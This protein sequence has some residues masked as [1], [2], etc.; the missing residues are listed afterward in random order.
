MVYNARGWH[1]SYHMADCALATSWRDAEN[2]TLLSNGIARVSKIGAISK[3]Q[4]QSEPQ[5]DEEL[6]TAGET[7]GTSAY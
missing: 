2:L 4:Q 6:S 1:A 3:I 7:G 5:A